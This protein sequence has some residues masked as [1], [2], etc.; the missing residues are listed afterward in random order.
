MAHILLVDDDEH[1]R[2][3]IGI[4]LLKEGYDVS[5]VGDGRSAIERVRR[6][7]SD[8]VLLDIMLPVLDG[9]EACRQIRQFS[10]V[11]I[12]MLSVKRSED[13][14]VRA[15]ETGADDYL[16]KPFGHRE[17]LAR[18]RALLRRPTA[19]PSVPEPPPNVEFG[20]D[21]RTRTVR[22]ADHC[23][24]LTPTEFRILS[25]LVESPGSVHSP[26][27]LLRQVNNCDYR[28]QEAREIVKVHIR[29]LRQKVERDPD[30]PDHIVNVR[31]VGY[32]FVSPSDESVPTAAF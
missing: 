29:R 17:L 19:P 23:V 6:D 10:P 24:S 13:D 16:T 11:P 26:E 25:C 32:S 5:A 7:Q 3:I 31:G 12:L 9:I 8:L 28:R 2:S 27:T 20:L 21:A 30:R 22:L 14:K 18:V 1:L 4:A 15:L